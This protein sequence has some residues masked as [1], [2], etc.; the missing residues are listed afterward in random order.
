MALGRV[1]PIMPSSD[2]SGNK[3]RRVMI[4][5]DDITDATAFHTTDNTGSTEPGS[6]IPWKY[7]DYI[8]LDLHN[9]HTGTVTV[10][11]SWGGG[12]GAPENVK[13]DLPT[14]NLPPLVLQ[15]QT[16]CGGAEVKFAA[17]VENVVS[18]GHRIERAQVAA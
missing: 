9:R 3:G 5:V 17:S 14:G 8:T 12:A 18:V 4:T 7:V 15:T 10:E 11:I 16:L 1:V 2:P 6:L 13:I